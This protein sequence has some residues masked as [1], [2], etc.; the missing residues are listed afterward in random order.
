MFT[1]VFAEIEILNWIW[2]D[3]LWLKHLEITQ[4]KLAV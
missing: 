4:L 1:Y 2:T 3:L